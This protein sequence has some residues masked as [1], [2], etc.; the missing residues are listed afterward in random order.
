MRQ[1]NSHAAGV[2]YVASQRHV[3]ALPDKGKQA[4]QQATATVV[5]DWVSWSTTPQPGSSLAVVNGSG[6]GQLRLI[7]GIVDNTTLAIESPFD[8]HLGRDSFVVVVNTYDKKLLAGNRFTFTEVIQ[9]FGVTL[10]GVIADNSIIDGNVNHSQHTRD[11]VALKYGG[12][13]RAVG[14]KTLTS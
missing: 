9:F 5:M 14:G 8:Q 11:P 2:G 10:G 6:M 7:V 13:M 4:Q 1:D 12:S 3:Q